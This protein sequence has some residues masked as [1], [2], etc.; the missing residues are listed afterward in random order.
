M[1]S[2]GHFQLGPPVK[3]DLTSQ[4]LPFE[5]TTNENLSETFSLANA[6]ARCWSTRLR[7]GYE[8]YANDSRADPA[9]PAVRRN[10]C[11]RLSRKRGS[12]EFCI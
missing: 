6:R 9:A 5:E 10:D 4:E 3:L 12:A 11:G 1:R 7:R 8:F 2:P